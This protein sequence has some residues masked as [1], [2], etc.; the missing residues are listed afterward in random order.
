[1][2]WDTSNRMLK[3]RSSIIKLHPYSNLMADREGICLDLNE[4][5]A[6]CSP[7]VAARLR[8]LTV[9][10]I[11]Q[12]PDR[13]AGER[14]AASFLCVAPERVLLTNGVDEGL[15]LLASAY[16]GEGA[17]MIFAE[18]TF[19]M[20]PTVGQS[21]GARLTPLRMGENFTYPTDELLK[22]ISPDTRLIAV[23]N[24]NNPTGLPVPRADLLRIVGAAP[25]AAVLV[26]EAYFDFYG[27]TSLP[28]VERHNNLFVAR[29]FSK[30]YGMA[31]VRLGVLVGPPEQIEYLRRFCPPFNV[32]AVALACLEEALADQEFVAAHVA[33][34]RQERELF[35]KLCLDLGLKSWP[36]RTNFV[37]V[38]VGARCREFVDAMRR[39]GVIVRDIS[40]SPGCEDCVRITIGTREEME[41][42]SAAL[43]TAVSSLSL[44]RI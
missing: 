18:P 10:D 11:A 20:Y 7:R 5:T 38:R 43:R 1:M 14:L 17:G 41:R 23:A 30:A 42:V 12:Y 40:A 25:D 33:Q 34:I 16:L 35:Q 31:G 9:D 3:P 28:E 22:V 8:S 37:L 2:L 27:E 21:V 32:N 26:D 24:P 13:E 36:S 4:N 6:G 29:T 44:H 19:V 15:F 39:C